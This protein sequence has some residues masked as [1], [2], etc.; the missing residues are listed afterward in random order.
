LDAP[1]T[2]DVWVTIK[3]MPLDKAPGPDGFT[4]RFNKSCWNIIKGDHVGFISHSSGTR[5]QI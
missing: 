3:D 4:G 5:V 2:E 1:F